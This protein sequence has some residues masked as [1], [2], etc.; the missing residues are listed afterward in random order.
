MA[1]GL[2]V[3]VRRI[4]PVEK[5]TDPDALIL[6]SWAQGYMVGSLIIMAA[7]TIAN[8][9]RGVLLH[10]LILLEVGPR[11]PQSA[12]S[13]EHATSFSLHSMLTPSASFYS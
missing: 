13:K 10:K 7:V 12:F 3:L 5:P 2:D 9:R 6:E 8:M 11:K 1:P 4:A